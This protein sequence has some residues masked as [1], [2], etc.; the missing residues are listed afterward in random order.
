MN[1][2]DPDTKMGVIIIGV[3][4]GVCVLSGVLLLIAEILR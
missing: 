2:L 3:Y 4:L 1:N